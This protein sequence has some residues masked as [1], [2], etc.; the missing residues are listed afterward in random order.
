MITSQQAVGKP[1]DRVDG[2]LKVTGQARYAAEWPIENVTYGALVLSTVASGRAKSIDVRAAERAPGVLAVITHHNAMRLRSLEQKQRPG[3]DPDFGE[4]LSP[5]QDDI[6]RYNGQPLAVV[7]ADTFERARYAASLVRVEYHDEGGITTF[8]QA[9]PH[10]QA[11]LEAGDS[12][13]KK[14][15]RSKDYRRGD[16]NAEQSK[17]EVRIEATYSMAAN[18]HNPMEPHVTIA[19]WDGPRLTLYDKTQWVDNVREQIALAFAMKTEDVR[20]IS[21]FVGGAFGSALRVWP[22]VLISALAARH[23]G[24]PVKLVLTRAQEF[25]VPGY[26]P[27]NVQT[28]SLA[29]TRDGKL[30]SIEH[31]GTNQTSTYEEYTESLLDPSRFMYACPNAATIYRLARMNVNTPASMR[32]PGEVSG[33]FA[34]ESAIDELAVAVGI[35][36]VVLRLRNHADDDPETGKPWSSKSLKECYRDAAE[37]FGWSRRNPQP[38]SMRE[39]HE[40]IGYGMASATWPA[41]RQPATIYVQLRSDGNAVVR[42]AASDIGPGT[43][44]VMTQIAADALGLPVGRVNFDLGDSSLPKA[45]VQGGSMTVASVGSAVYEVCQAALAKVLELTHGDERSP[46]KGATF[47]QTVAGD[48]RLFLKSD[49]SRGEPI[50]EILKRHGRQ[51]IELTQESKPGGDAKKYTT[52]SFG[53]HFVEVRVDADLG[54]IRVARVVS[55]LAAGRII[56]PKTAGSQAIGGIVGGIGMALLEETVWDERNARIVNANLADYHVPVHADIRHIDA[57]YVEEHDT[58]VNPIGAKGLAELSIVGVAAAVANAVYHATGKR[59]REVP[60]TPDKLL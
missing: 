52:R 27:Q 47:D 6:V 32:G 8:A 44:T 42:T 13:K 31:K 30:T 58:H 37:Q 29:A 41:M 23:V 14:A 43:Y 19:M 15:Q 20:V 24:R 4:P 50:A 35:D 2:R 33:M 17:A 53:A 39:G 11:P 1:L 45:P 10:A 12:N 25:T 21:P 40:L 56:N 49:P 9:V 16:P 55:R 3:V 60:I 18:H 38:R 22:H 57:R 7:V 34:L 5:L 26:R 48:G 36:P 46:L 51:S 28:V 54:A 59:I